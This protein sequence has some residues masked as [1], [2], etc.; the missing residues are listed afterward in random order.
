MTAFLRQ[1]LNKMM[2]TLLI[3]AVSEDV[4]WAVPT[5]K[6]FTHVLSFNPHNNDLK[7]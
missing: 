6:D 4:Q 7:K 1:K 5:A 2:L 3:V